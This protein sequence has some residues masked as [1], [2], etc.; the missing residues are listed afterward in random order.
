MRRTDVYVAVGGVDQLAGTLTVRGRG[1]LARSQFVYDPEFAYGG[2]GF[3]LAPGLPVDDPVHGFRGIPLFVQDAGP[4]LW[5]AHLLRRAALAKDRLASLD[6]LDNVLGASDFARQGALRFAD[7]T[8]G[9]FLSPAPVPTH[10]DLEDLLA[11]ADDVASE[12]P[13]FSPIARLLATGTS[14]LGG[15][16]AKA[17]VTDESGQLWMAKFPMTTDRCNVPAWEKVALDLAAHAR[18]E[19]PESRLVRAAGRD[20]LLLRRFDRDS[21]G[22]IPYLSFRSLLGNADDGQDPPDYLHIAPELR[23]FTDTRGEDLFRRAAFGVMVNNTDNH[24]RNMGLLRVGRAW[25]SAPMFDVNPEPE[26]GRER[27]TSI[28]GRYGLIRIREGLEE[29]G[30]ACGLDQRRVQD[31]LTDLHDVVQGWRGLAEAYGI[32]EREIDRMGAAFDAVAEHVQQRPAGGM[33]PPAAPVRRAKTT[34]GST[35][36]SFAPRLRSEPES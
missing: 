29:L 19:V 24:L 25:R 2:Q 28:A 22:R 31:E 1:D 33:R 15:A 7:P 6:D 14:A 20:V 13:S 26:S 10:V 16:R 3:D 30:R 32:A 11:D 4:D 23:A 18:I 9:T 17:S 5:G 8:T 21:T 35:S 12:N 27:H 34:P 36:G